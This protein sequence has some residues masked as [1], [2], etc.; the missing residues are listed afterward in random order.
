M[1]RYFFN[2]EGSGGK[3]T[4]ATIN[5]CE[6]YRYPETRIFFDSFPDLLVKIHTTTA[7]V[8]AKKKQWM[9]YYAATHEKEQLQRW[10]SVIDRVSFHT[11]GTIS[12]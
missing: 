6:W 10:K 1:P 2:S 5:L 11:T 7:A 3:I 4:P 8:I 9:Q 12:D